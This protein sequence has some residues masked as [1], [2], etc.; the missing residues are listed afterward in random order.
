MVRAIFCKMFPIISITSSIVLVISC[1]SL[2]LCLEAHKILDLPVSCQNSTGGLGPICQTHYFCPY[3]MLGT[4]LVQTR[5]QRDVGLPRLS[6]FP[7]GG[8]GMQIIYVP[9]AQI[10]VVATVRLG[11]P[12]PL[13]PSL[14]SF[15][16]SPHT[17]C[18]PGRSSKNEWVVET[19]TQRY[20]SWSTG[21]A[22]SLPP[23]AIS[24][25]SLTAPWGKGQDTRW[26]TEVWWGK[27]PLN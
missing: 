25:I 27:N 13:L 17:D 6:V 18:F 5:V 2:V 4:Q 8:G 12:A 24:E 10:F 26:V 14:L 21:F 1:A 16:S 9:D 11:T 19:Q 3:V 15:A 22:E 20:D 7:L 23:K